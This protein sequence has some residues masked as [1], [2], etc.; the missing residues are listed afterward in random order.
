MRTILAKTKSQITIQ[1]VARHAGVSI[2]TVSRV[3][4][5]SHLVADQTRAAVTEAIEEL[6]YLP[7]RTARALAGRK[8]D[9]LVVAVPTFTTPFHN[10]L[11]KGIREAANEYGIEL[12]LW[13]L[14]WR[15]A[16]QALSRFISRGAVSGL[17]LVGVSVNRRILKDLAS[18]RSPVVVV[19][20]RS[21]TFDS[22]Y[23]ND[24]AGARLAVKHLLDQG[25]RR[26]G[27]IRAAST[28]DIQNRR[29]AG[30]M[31]ALET[32]GVPYDPSLVAGGVT[33][34][35]AGFS[36][37]SGYEA[38][39]RLLEFEPRLT[40][41]FASSDVQA[42]GAWKAAADVG[43]RVPQDIALVGY[44]D[45]KVSRFIGLS[46]I[47][48]KPLEVGR[49]AAATLLTRIRREGP[50]RI[51]VEQTMPRLR[52]RSSSMRQVISE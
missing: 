4:N 38:M 52:V 19:G 8:L 47:D 23:W 39:Q 43:L 50:K 29:L 51:Y 33:E 17:L 16:E 45:I 11:L 35:H 31:Q 3:L 1:D 44:D 41:V 12:L 5:N 40:G 30:Y 20:A 7:D 14:E 49:Q 15:S 26:I 9:P 21:E 13:D 37:E 2:A 10:E 25:H 32:A 27:M 42:I 28:S 6:Q 18:L 22:F 48:Q 34:K 36:E 46:S 24:E